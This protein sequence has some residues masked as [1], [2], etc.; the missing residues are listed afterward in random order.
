M[1]ASDGTELRTATQTKG[2]CN[3]LT[4]PFS[5]LS[6]KKDPFFLLFLYFSSFSSS[7]LLHTFTKFVHLSPH[8]FYG[9]NFVPAN[10]IAFRKPAASDSVLLIFAI[11]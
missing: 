4:Q 1:N 6:E 7:C 11:H 10:K 5:R 8:K 2:H 3:L 9:C